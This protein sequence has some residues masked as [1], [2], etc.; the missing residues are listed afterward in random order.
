MNRDITK[1]LNLM[2]LLTFLILIQCFGCQSRNS[3][4]KSSENLIVNTEQAK[5]SVKPQEKIPKN[6]TDY[7]KTNIPHWIIPDTSDYLKAWWS[8]HESD[9]LPFFA[10]T[11]INGDSKNDYAFILKKENE[12]GL[13]ILLNTEKT[14]MLWKTD[15][16]KESFTGKNIQYGV[17][18]EESGEY[19]YYVNGLDKTLY[20]QFK[21]IALMDLEFKLRIY[22]W[23]NGEIKSFQAR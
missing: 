9:A 20:L 4:S 23:E 7:L 13:F 10:I 14:F 19:N 22:Y 18:A 8:F 17:K 2:R 16:F 6:V 21:A 15:D 3:G 1:H 11:D 5:P 12:L